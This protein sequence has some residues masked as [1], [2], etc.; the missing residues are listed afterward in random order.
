MGISNSHLPLDYARCTGEGCTIRTT[1]LR[2]LHRNDPGLWVPRTTPPVGYDP[3]A[4]VPCRLYIAV[5]PCMR[6]KKSKLPKGQAS[7]LSALLIADALL[8]SAPSGSLVSQ[9][10][11]EVKHALLERFEETRRMLIESLE[12]GSS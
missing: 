6:M 8:I 3:Q 2:W 12:G 1:C 11:H 5:Q 9:Q 7:T 10:P 4:T